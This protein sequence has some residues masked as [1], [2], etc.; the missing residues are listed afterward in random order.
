MVHHLL[1]TCFIVLSKWWALEGKIAFV[2]LI[3]C[4]IGPCIYYVFIVL[5]MN[6]GY[7]WGLLE[8]NGRERES[9]RVKPPCGCIS[10]FSNECFLEPGNRISMLYFHL[11]TLSHSWVTGTTSSAYTIH[12]PTQLVHLALAFTRMH[13]WIYL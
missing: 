3:L 10:C 6:L 7:C 2:P 1:F 11:T 12:H 5:I 4:G 13:N 9:R 8:L